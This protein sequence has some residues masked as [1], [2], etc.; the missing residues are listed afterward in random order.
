MQGSKFVIGAIIPG[1]NNQATKE[2]VFV[3]VRVCFSPF[4]PELSAY[5]STPFTNGVVQIGLIDVAVYAKTKAPPVLLVLC[6]YTCITCQSEMEGRPG[7]ICSCRVMS[8]GSHIGKGD[9][10]SWPTSQPCESFVINPT[11]TQCLCICHN[12]QMQGCVYTLHHKAYHVQCRC[13][14]LPVR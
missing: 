14:C 1:S 11:Y 13:V 3:V 8:G 9:L 10:W 5:V 2:D 12:W 7:R 6:R 4:A